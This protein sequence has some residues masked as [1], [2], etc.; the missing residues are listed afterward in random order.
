MNNGF[1]SNEDLSCLFLIS[2][3]CVNYAGT[4][5]LGD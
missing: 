2:N 3:P 4:A 5:C 1:E